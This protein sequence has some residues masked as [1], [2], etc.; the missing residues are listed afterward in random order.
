MRCLSGFFG[1]SKAC[2]FRCYFRFLQGL[3]RPFVVSERVLQGFWAPLRVSQG[4][5]RINKAVHRG[6]IRLLF[7]FPILTVTTA[8]G[9]KATT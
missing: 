1:F 6:F 9:K 3:T 5:L 7:Y 2:S 8:N 4:F